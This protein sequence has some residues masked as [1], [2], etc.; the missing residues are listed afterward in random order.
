MSSKPLV[1]IITIFWNAE[2]YIQEAIESAI[3][4]TYEHWELL[5]VD[6]GSMDESTNIALS[7]ARQYPKQI[8]YLEHPDH[9]NLGMSATRNLGIRSS[10]GEYLSFLDA[11]DLWLSDKLEQQVNILE[12]RPE[13][14]FLCSPAKWWYSWSSN[15][16]ENQRDF[17]QQLGVPSNSMVQPPTL[18]L[19]FLQNEWASLCDLLVRGSVVEK[20]GG[21]E[22]SFQGMY[23]DQAFHAKLCLQ[24]ESFVTS[25]CWYWY[26]QH[27]TACT[28]LTHQAKQWRSARYTFLNWLERYLVQQEFQNTEIWQ[29]LQKEIWPFRHPVLFRVSNR[30]QSVMKTWQRSKVA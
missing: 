15:V 5:L 28:A 19:K 30:V 8:R 11:D 27:P 20:I 23:E 24:S 13:T 25:Q 14:A 4:Q 1:S 26:R 2:T 29:V 16:E 9:Q 7:Y 17:V 21:Y 6:D 18:L 10:K 22:T 3:A 12:S